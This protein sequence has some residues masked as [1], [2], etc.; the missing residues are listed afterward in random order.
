MTTTI[1]LNSTTVLPLFQWSWSNFFIPTINPL[2]NNKRIK[3]ILWN[4]KKDKIFE[5]CLSIGLSTF[6]M[7]RLSIN[8]ENCTCKNSAKEKPGS[9]N[10]PG[11]ICTL[12]DTEGK[13]TFLSSMPKED[14][15]LRHG[16]MKHLTRNTIV[17]S[18]LG[19]RR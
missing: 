14:S 2:K 10:F 15:V 18:Q 17:E 13:W 16:G 12:L 4:I 11:S 1:H 19:K 5:K 7:I 8:P 9:G 6:H 3:I